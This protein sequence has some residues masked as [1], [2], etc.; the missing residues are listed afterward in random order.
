MGSSPWLF[1]HQPSGGGNFLQ[2]ESARARHDQR[3]T[4]PVPAEPTTAP[5]LSDLGQGTVEETQVF[6]METQGGL[7]WLPPLTAVDVVD[8]FHNL[9]C[10]LLKG[11]P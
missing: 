4:L 11:V 9:D 3:Q 1:D 5:V 10:S 2:H 8:L 7:N 6:F